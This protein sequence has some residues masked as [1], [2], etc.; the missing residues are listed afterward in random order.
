MK[1]SLIM[2]PIAFLTLSGL[3]MAALTEP[4]APAAP[5][6]GA[7]GSDR[8]IFQMKSDLPERT[9]RYSASGYDITPLSDEK[10]KELA[11]KLDRESYRIL[12]ES[13]T[14]RPGSG[15]LLKND[16][17][18]VYVCKLCGLPLFKSGDKYD[19][20]TGWPSYFDVYDP[21]HVVGVVDRSYGM[22]RIEVVCARSGAHL[23]H[24]FDDGPEPT[25]LRFCIN[26]AAMT[27]YEEG[28]D[29]PAESR[30]VET[31]TAYFAGGCFWGI[32]HYFGKGPGVLEAVS[33]YQQGE[34]DNPTYEQVIRGDTGHAET[35]KVIFDPQRISYRELVEVFFRMIDPTQ[36][37]RQGPDR[38]TQY[39]SGIWFTSDE[40]REV[41]EKYI[42][43]L[44]KSGPFRNR[45]I[46]TAVEEAKTFWKAEEHHQNYIARTGRACHVRNPW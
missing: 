22:Q 35:V 30:P 18:G 3:L 25:G 42:E 41:A 31:E 13:G 5:E 24:V 46:V 1:T 14:E 27:F 9:P 11:G 15:E 12:I 33:G 45:T 38:G 2:Y 32:E 8:P 39:R 37:N 29:M 34:V 10:I 43:Q 23:G 21:Q 4:P 26:S 7:K 17:S 36:L 20:R 28:Q 6:D 19:S 44:Q 16:R 40:Q